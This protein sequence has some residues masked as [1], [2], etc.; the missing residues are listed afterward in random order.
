MLF[1][2]SKQYKALGKQL[3]L[4]SSMLM[5]PSYLVFQLSSESSDVPSIYFGTYISG[6]CSV[7]PDCDRLYATIFWG[8][9]LPWS[10]P[11]TISGFMVGGWY[12][13]FVQVIVLGIS[14]LVYF[15]FLNSEDKLACE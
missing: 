2:K 14:T 9:S 7:W 12:V 10:T 13:P 11:A 8:Y 5:N 15:P 6:C 1:A 4:Q 3:F